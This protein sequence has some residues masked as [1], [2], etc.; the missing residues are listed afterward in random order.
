MRITRGAMILL[1]IQIGLSLVWVMSNKEVRATIGEY[2]VASPSQV[3]E[4]YRVWTLVTSP[5][6]E[7]DF[8]GLIFTALMMWMLV[9]TLER[10][11]GTKRFYR[12]V[13]V[14]SIAATLAGTLM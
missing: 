10:F 6:L 14:T 3:F 9:P 8:I 7:I 13:A 11:W 12:F 4:Q 1:G 2:L 5:L